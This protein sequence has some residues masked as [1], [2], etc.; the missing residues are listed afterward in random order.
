MAD[1]SAPPP[2]AL[3]KL[4]DSADQLRFQ[5]SHLARML[6][7]DELAENL[8]VAAAMLVRFEAN[9]REFEAERVAERIDPKMPRYKGMVP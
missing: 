9:L 5:L 2:S 1:E 4:A 6:G 7:K 3:D 8:K